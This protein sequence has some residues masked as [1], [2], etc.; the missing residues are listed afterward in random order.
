[1]AEPLD[2]LRAWQLAGDAD[3]YEL[4]RTLILIKLR[5]HARRDGGRCRACGPLGPGEDIE[6]HQAA[7]IVR[8]LGET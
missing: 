3:F 4:L 7:L 2:R 5:I 8:A 6:S 1:M